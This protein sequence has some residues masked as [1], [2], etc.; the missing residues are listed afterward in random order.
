MG[1]PLL[2]SDLGLTA[3]ALC[4]KPD[5]LRASHII[6]R[7]VFEW[8]R[9]SSATGHIRSGEQPNLRVQDGWKPK[10]LCSPCEQRFS[11]WEKAFAEQI[12]VPLNRGDA[13]PFTYGPWLLKFATSVSWRV[14]TAYKLIGGLDDFPPEHMRAADAA[15]RTWRAFLLGEEAHPGAYQQHVFCVDLIE[16]TDFPDLP[17]NFNRYLTRGVDMDLAH[18]GPESITYAKMGRVVLFGFVAMPHPRRWQGTKINANEGSISVAA[19]HLP[20]KVFE[21]MAGKARKMAAHYR[22]ISPRQHEVI[23]RAYEENEERLAGSEVFRAMQQD[24]AMFGEAAFY[25]NQEPE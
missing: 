22:A 23:Q 19:Y 9:E 8:L 6:P 4:G 7:Y 21:F 25:S 20:G 11:V 13:P 12:F 3:C 24:V 1:K 18:G 17:P 2:V 14:L 10:L 16:T 5:A 15:L